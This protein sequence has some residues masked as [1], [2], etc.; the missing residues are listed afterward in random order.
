[1]RTALERSLNI[2]SIKLLERVGIQSAI[3][4]A[5]KMGI[6]SKLEPGLALTLGASEVSILEMAS[7]FG[8]FANGGLR[9]DPTAI[10]KIENRDGVTL[11]SHRIIERRVLDENVA[12]IMID[13]MKGV[14]T[15]GTGVRGQIDRPAAAKTGTSQDFKD[16]WFVGFVPQLVTG[17]W[18]GNDDN[19][20]MQGVAEVAICPRIW[21]AYNQTVLAGQPVLDFPVP[22]GLV[23]VQ[24][25]LVSGKLAGPNCPSNLITWATLWQREVPGSNCNIHVTG[26]ES[27]EPS[28]E[29]ESPEPLEGET[30]EP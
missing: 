21:K 7:A 29:A 26:E 28:G 24:L 27:L 4:V 9:V 18:V 16:A 2:P 13:M 22:E 23:N 8:V 25:C 3:E 20:P 14:L 15:R 6:K 10:T 5:Q 19:K 30:G 17:V 1:M 12:A 11:Y